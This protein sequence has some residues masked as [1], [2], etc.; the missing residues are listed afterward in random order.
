MRFHAHTTSTFIEPGE[1]E[2]APVWLTDQFIRAVHYDMFGE[3]W[4]WAGKYR[5]GPVNIGVDFHL[6]P[7]QIKLLCGDFSYL[8]LRQEFD[9]AA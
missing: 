6:I 9:A 4:E 3:I 7:E 1:K 5:T 8:E 2:P